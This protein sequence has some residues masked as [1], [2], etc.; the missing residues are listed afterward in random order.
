M[1]KKRLPV[2]DNADVNRIVQAVLQ[3]TDF[4]AATPE[5]RGDLAY[6]VALCVAG[7]DGLSAAWSE[8]LAKKVRQRILWAKP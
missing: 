5:W 3:H 2:V 4:P 1:N 6:N 7:Q 8:E